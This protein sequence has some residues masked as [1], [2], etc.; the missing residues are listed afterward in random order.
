[1]YELPSSEKKKLEIDEAYANEALNKNLLKRLEIALKI[2][3]FSNNSPF[4]QLNGFLWV[5]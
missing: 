4:I 2:T 1:M 5:N 3:D